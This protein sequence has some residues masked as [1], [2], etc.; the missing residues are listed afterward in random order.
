VRLTP[1]ANGT[2]IGGRNSGYNNI[3]I[4]GALF[5]NAFGLSGTVGGQANAQPISLDAV[6]QIAVSIAPYDV[7]EGSFTGA[8][9]NVV[10]R[11]G[12]NDIQ[13]SAYYFTRNQILSV[14]K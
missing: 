14:K 4:D 7:R 9:V 1:Q 5:N 6:D 3:T 12:T 10:T 11:S 13:G 8:G 2:S